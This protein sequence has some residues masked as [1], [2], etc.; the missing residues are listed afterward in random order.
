LFSVSLELYILDSIGQL[1]AEQA[2]GIKNMEHKLSATFGVTGDWHE[3]IEK[4][5]DFPDSLPVQIR[6]IWAR[7]LANAAEVGAAVDPNAF[8]MAFA[9]QNF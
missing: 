2:T 7:N 9:D 5:M 6:S 8:A 4:T 1:D 3:I